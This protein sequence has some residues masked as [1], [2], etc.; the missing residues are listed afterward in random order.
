ML[1]GDIFKANN[2]NYLTIGM[3]LAKII[4]FQKL[5]LAAAVY[6][7]ISLHGLVKTKGHHRD[8]YESEE[9]ARFDLFNICGGGGV[10]E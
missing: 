5:L 8:N 1:L 2:V 6:C 3:F 7:I 4:L 10:H 9:S